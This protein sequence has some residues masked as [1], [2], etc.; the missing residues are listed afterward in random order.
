MSCYGL[1]CLALRKVA[2]ILQR[3]ELERPSESLGNVREASGWANAV[4]LAL[5]NHHGQRERPG[6]PARR[7][8]ARPYNAPSA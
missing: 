8:V 6:W 2:Y 5:N 3:H 7:A 1:R 4:R